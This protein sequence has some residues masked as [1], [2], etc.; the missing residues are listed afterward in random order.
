MIDTMLCYAPNIQE[1]MK[2]KK[3]LD[4]FA[5]ENDSVFIDAVCAKCGGLRWVVGYKNKDYKNY[6]CKFCQEKQKEFQE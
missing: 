5:V 2:I 1:E 6:V 3:L 4:T